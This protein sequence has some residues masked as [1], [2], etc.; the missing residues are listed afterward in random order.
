MRRSGHLQLK[1]CSARNLSKDKT[2]YPYIQLSAGTF[3]EKTPTRKCSVGQKNVYW[4]H[5]FTLFMG[6]GTVL[7]IEIKNKESFLVPASTIGVA[8]FRIPSNVSDLQ[9]LWQPI[10]DPKTMQPSKAELHLVLQFQASGGICSPP[11]SPN[12]SNSMFVSG[13]SGVTRSPRG[14]DLGTGRDFPG[15]QPG[16]RVARGGSASVLSTSPLGSSKKDLALPSGHFDGKAAAATINELMNSLEQVKQIIEAHNQEGGGSS[17]TIVVQN[18]DNERMQMLR[19]TRNEL[20]SIRTQIESEESLSKEW[21]EKLVNL[22]DAYGEDL[23]ILLS[24][25]AWHDVNR[26]MSTRA[27]SSTYA[28][29]ALAM[30]PI[31]DETSTFVEQTKDFT[32]DN[33]EL[34]D[35]LLEEGFALQVE[36]PGTPLENGAFIAKGDTITMEYTVFIWDSANSQA[37]SYDDS[38]ASGP[39]QFTVGDGDVPSG[40]CLG[41]EGL[42]LNA[43]FVLTISPALAYGEAGTDHVPPDT[44]IL[45]EGKIIQVSQTSISLQQGFDDDGMIAEANKHKA[46][47]R[48][49]ARQNRV[50]IASVPVSP[51]DVPVGKSSTM[52]ELTQAFVEQ[53]NLAKEEQAQA[54]HT[55]PPLP[56]RSS[57]YS[58]KR[59]LVSGT[60]N[61]NL[62][63]AAPGPVPPRPTSSSLSKLSE[64][65]TVDEWLNQIG[66][67]AY[68]PALHELGVE[69]F[70]DLE[71]VLESDLKQMGMRL[72]Q[73]RKFAAQVNKLGIPFS[74]GTS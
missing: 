18:R 56:P 70:G 42:G 4:N 31:K 72:I 25:H 41:V 48:Y 55:P 22:A 30:P 50:S 52:E 64:P 16:G 21:K 2:L 57:E 27:S 5:K 6:E 66:F 74:L 13:P 71:L 46:S 34:F 73:V 62:P 43:E 60:S 12:R 14:S 39:L 15:Q 59:S 37:V 33:I 68:A 61:S 69:D 28:S 17:G 3:R 54:K 19:N 67:Q 10:L 36:S 23:S 40:L 63:R 35:T 65:E 45:Y 20:D 7:K 47:V 26:R 8:E 44:H 24:T 53:T 11:M 29:P 49:P 38:K 32:I 51:I 1:V 9:D 58:S